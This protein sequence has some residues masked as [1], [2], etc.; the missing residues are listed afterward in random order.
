MVAG[1]ATAEPT[2]W[3]R[4]W[5]LGRVKNAMGAAPPG[6]TPL[7]EPVEAITFQAWPKTPRLFRSMIITEKIDG[8]NGAIIITDDGQIAAIPK[9]LAG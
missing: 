5:R 1:P 2:K 7:E 9:S 4:A 8:T 3:A 6:A